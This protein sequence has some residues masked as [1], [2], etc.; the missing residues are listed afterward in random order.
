MNAGWHRR[1]EPLAL[2]RQVKYPAAIFDF[3]GTLA[4]SFPWFLRRI[5]LLAAEFHFKTVQSS[6]YEALRRMDTR[7]ILAHLQVPVWK[8]PLIARRFRSWSAR[9]VAEI[10]LFPGVEAMFRELRQG[11]IQ[12]AL[13][14][15]NGG[16]TICHVLGPAN[17]ARF[18][19]IEGGSSL[20]GK[21]RRLRKVPF[22]LGVSAADCI[23]IGDELR[24]ATAA[25]QAG[26]AFGAVA[27]GY[28]RIETLRRHQPAAEFLEPSEVTRFLLD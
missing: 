13:V 22:R 5:N 21:A 11:G 15:S 25:A 2:S 17:M 4:D 10:P 1:N 6:D 19:W 24:D 27:W 28:T 8:L 23:Y 9:D 12:L 16:T 7:Q 26:L 18:R 14:S 3:D 20:L